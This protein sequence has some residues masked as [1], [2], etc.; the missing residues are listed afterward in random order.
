MCETDEYRV[1][2][3]QKVPTSTVMQQFAV[4][5]SCSTQPAT[6]VNPNSV[7]TL[8]YACNTVKIVKC[9]VGC[10]AFGQSTDSSVSEG[11]SAHCA[12][13]SRAMVT[14]EDDSCVVL[15]SFASDELADESHKQPPCLSVMSGFDDDTD[16]VSC[17]TTVL[18]TSEC[19]L[20]NVAET[21]E[22]SAPSSIG[23]C[24]SSDDSCDSDDD[25]S[26]ETHVVCGAGSAVDCDIDEQ[27]VYQTF[28]SC[29]EGGDVSDEQQ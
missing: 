2:S 26:Q 6:H 7:C 8:N 12:S 28:E 17:A 3:E 23:K 24:C 18:C 13:L 4:S 19:T 5:D 27:S 9:R 15:L 10:D 14:A 11:Y 20:D 29:Y 16:V 21:G 25:D 22:R 1:V